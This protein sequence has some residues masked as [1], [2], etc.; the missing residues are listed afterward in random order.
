[1]FQVLTL[2]LQRPF[3][4]CVTVELKPTNP[5]RVDLVIR[6]PNQQCDFTAHR[7]LATMRSLWRC[8][9]GFR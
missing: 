1:M 8:N 3:K 9:T 7:R 4:F 5:V 6:F 2:E